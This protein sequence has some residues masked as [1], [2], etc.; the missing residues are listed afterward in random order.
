[1]T[2]TALEVLAGDDTCCLFC[3]A[4]GVSIVEPIVMTA[5]TEAEPPPGRT[6]IRHLGICQ[7]CTIRLARFWH[8]REQVL[9]QVLG[10]R[11]GPKR[12]L[13]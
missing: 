8:A 6:G 1:M 9:G 7:P 10:D 2:T 12:G 4:K 5:A 13:F 11:S 3:A